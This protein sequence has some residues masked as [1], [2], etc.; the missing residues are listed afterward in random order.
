MAGQAFIDDVTLLC[1]YG[2]QILPY[3]DAAARLRIEVFRDYPYLYEGTVT[4][5][6][7][8][9][10]HYVDCP[11]SIFVCAMDGEKVVGIS[12]ALPL[13]AADEAFQKPFLDA[14]EQI[15]KIFYL[16]ESV[17]LS[18]YRS[19]GIGHL[20]FHHREAHAKKLGC[21]ITTFC[22]VIRPD[23]HPLKPHGYRNNESFWHKRGYQRNGL[24]AKF[25]WKE[26][27][28]QKETSHQMEFWSRKME[29]FLFTST[30]G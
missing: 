10:E 9:L 19:L 27:N 4:Y 26:V 7:E 23:D 11:E 25:D 22:S 1:C 13:V 24:H 14:S 16:G 29:Q 15:Q 3:L 2:E 18:P 8:Y 5:E 17:L 21:D 6:R 20:F 12:T 30:L 28:E